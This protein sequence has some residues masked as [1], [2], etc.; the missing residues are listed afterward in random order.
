MTTDQMVQ[1]LKSVGAIFA[2]STAKFISPNDPF[3]SRPAYHIHPD[4][5]YPHEKQIVRV[6]SQKQL[7]DWVRTAK[8]AA[9]AS[10]ED[11]FWL[12]TAYEDRWS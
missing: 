11:A 7:I 10:Q 3:G 8:A 2:T 9:R 5:E 6:Y 12:W 4:A 1:A